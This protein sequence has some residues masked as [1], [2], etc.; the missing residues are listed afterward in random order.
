MNRQ[1]KE[2]FLL[3]KPK[4]PGGDQA[5]LEQIRKDLRYPEKAIADNIEGTVRVKF[6][7][8]HLGK[9]EQ[10][11]VI[12]G[13]GHGCDEEAVRLIKGLQFSTPK[14]YH[15]RGVLFHRTINIHFKLPNI[16]PLPE[17]SSEQQSTLN[18]QYTITTAT[19]PTSP[20][21]ATNQPNKTYQYTVKW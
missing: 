20:T 11:Q 5:M 6:S 18:M 3:Q 17:P 2:K 1:K 7:I 4:F 15:H 12:H 13:I 14:Q 9:V 21:S 16:K 10:V 19:K 8:N